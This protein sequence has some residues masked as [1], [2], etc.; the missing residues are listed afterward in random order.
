[1]EKQNAYLSDGTLTDVILIRGEPIPEGLHYIFCEVLVRH[2]DGDF[3]IMKR[4]RKKLMNPSKWEATVGGCALLG[5]NEFDCIKRELYEE[6][7]INA[8]NFIDIGH[9][10]S[11]VSLYYNYFCIVDCDKDSIIL[12]DG[13]TEDYKWLGK[14]EFLRFLTTDGS[15]E[16]QRTRLTEFVNSLDD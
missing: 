6:T 16:G 1:M 13:E 7:G 8:D 12:Q 9:G 2:T 4:S 14:S 15:I 5:E 3:L 11:S 10:V